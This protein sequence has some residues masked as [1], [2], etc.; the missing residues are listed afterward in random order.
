M[1][2][3]TGPV[4]VAINVTAP[5]G[6]SIF[7]TDNGDTPTSAS[8]EYT[9]PLLIEETTTLKAIGT[10]AGYTNS[11]VATVQI[12]IG[13]TLYFG[14]SPLA[15]L[16]EAQI[17]ALSNSPLDSS[18]T[19]VTSLRTYTFG[20]GSTTSDYY[21]FWWPNTLENPT[22]ANGFFDPIGGSAVAMATNTEGFTDGPINGYYYKAVTVNGILG[23]LFRTFYPV[24]NGAQTN[25]LVQ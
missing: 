13:A 25:I 10:F 4:N 22:A 11:V 21:Y 23:R 12:D 3:Y 5:V 24:G 2:S 17:L 1:P 9:T 15:I 16:T 6:A 14:Y 19:S 7:Y 18:T 8:T 20:A